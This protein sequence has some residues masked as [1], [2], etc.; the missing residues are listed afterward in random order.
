[1]ISQS[2]A[3]EFYRMNRY[4]RSSD[5]SSSLAR[6]AGEYVTHCRGLESVMDDPRSV[7]PDSAPTTNGIEFLDNVHV[8]CYKQT[9]PTNLDES[10][11]NMG[12]EPNFD[13]GG[14]PL[15]VDNG[16]VLDPRL[17]RIVQALARIAAE[18]D[19]AAATDKPKR[20]TV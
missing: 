5:S 16:L 7:K 18:E 6:A 14:M 15:K 20:G 9:S 11:K 17:V 19:F 13:L 10:E 8:S 12:I 3:R 2:L 1:M 4:A